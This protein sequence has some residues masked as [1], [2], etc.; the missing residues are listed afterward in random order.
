MGK[1]TRVHFVPGGK[2][3]S[4]FAIEEEW[5]R[6]KAFMPYEAFFS[7]E[8][9]IDRIRLAVI[10]DEIEANAVVFCWQGQEIDVDEYG[11]LS[12]WPDD[13]CSFGTDLAFNIW[14][15]GSAKAREMK[16]K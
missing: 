4:D 6:L 5:Q 16:G 12:P 3:V 8:N 2:A 15:E 14:A 1:V 11:Q 13:F 7:T 10:R 9:M